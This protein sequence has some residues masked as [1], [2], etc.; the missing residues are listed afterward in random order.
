M[1]RRAMLVATCLVVSLAQTAAG[2]DDADKKAVLKYLERLGGQLGSTDRSR[3]SQAESAIRAVHLKMAFVIQ[4]AA[5]S[6]RK[7]PEREFN[8]VFA[9]KLLGDLRLAEAVPFLVEQLEFT[10]PM[11]VGT[12]VSGGWTP[13]V[14]TTPQLYALIQIGMPSLEPLLKKVVESQSPLIVERA[15]VVVDGVLGPDLAPLFVAKR[16]ERERDDA[17]RARL[18]RLQEE[19]GKLEAARQRRAPSRK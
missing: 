9:M 13:L 4:Y 7:S 18:L 14:Q 6:S 16:V 11:P 10:R 8:V 3:M 19:I 5:Y 12:G 2:D 17:K 1:I 15:A